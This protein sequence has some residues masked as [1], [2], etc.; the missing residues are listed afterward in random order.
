MSDTITKQELDS[1]DKKLDKRFD[2]VI[3]IM[4]TFMQHTDERF[5]KVEKDIEDIKA[6]LDRLTNTLD[7]F[8]KRLDDLE[9][10]N[11]AR[12]AQFER[13][14]IWAREVS[15]KTGIPMPQL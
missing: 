10:E 4:Q 12:D 1:L 8:I 14:K 3:D 5:N 11:A 15:K 7:G 6:S 2:D 13:L 9:A